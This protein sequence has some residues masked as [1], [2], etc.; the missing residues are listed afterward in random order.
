MCMTGRIPSPAFAKPSSIVRL[1][2]DD[3]GQDGAAGRPRWLIWRRIRGPRVEVSCPVG[4]YR[5]Y[6][7]GIKGGPVS[8]LGN[9]PRGENPL[10]VS[11][12]G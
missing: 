2:P 5:T 1:A 11:E 12:K 6:P 9:T 7:E 10:G 8:N 3:G 4:I